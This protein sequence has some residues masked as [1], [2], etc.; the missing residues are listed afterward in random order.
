MDPELALLFPGQGSQFVGM[1]RGL[2]VEFSEVR[3]CFERADDELFAQIDRPLSRYIFP[4]PAFTPA[5]RARASEELKATQVAQ[6]A[7]GVCGVAVLRLLES[8]GVRPDMAAG[9]SYG[10]LVALH[11]A[12]CFGERALHRLSRER[13]EAMLDLAREGSERDLGGMLAVVADEPCRV[14]DERLPDVQRV[15]AFERAR[16]LEPRP[17]AADRRARALVLMQAN[18]GLG[19]LRTES[20]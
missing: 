16:P 2:A 9:H 12:G 15:L 17:S 8:F 6:P 20:R 11:A 5:D 10:E 18:F 7:L 19:T 1:L 3:A 14:C 4:P 13:G